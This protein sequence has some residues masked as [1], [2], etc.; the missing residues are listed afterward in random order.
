M[1]GGRGLAGGAP[2]S[3]VRSVVL[4]GT[5]IAELFAA[6]TMPDREQD[7]SASETVVLAAKA[8]T[9]L[10][11]GDVLVSVTPGGGGYGDPLR[12]GPELVARDVRAGLVSEAAARDAYGVVAPG[13]VCDPQATEELRDELRAARRRDGQAAGEHPDAPQ[14]DGRRHPVSDTIESVGGWLRCTVCG[15]ALGA[16]GA[17]QRSIGARRELPLTALGARFAGCAPQFVLREL[18]CPGCG[19]AFN[20]DVQERGEPPLEGARLR[21]DWH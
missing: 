9:P 14:A 12:R 20:L 5:N 15:C 16:A 6:G 8:V 3:P 7:L 18:A 21:G 2:G 10:A 17:D 1:P 4:R 13:G 19:T 11:E